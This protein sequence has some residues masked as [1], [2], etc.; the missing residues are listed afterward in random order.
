[1]LFW[2]ASA[3]TVFQTADNRLIFQLSIA[4]TIS[5]SSL[6]LKMLSLICVQ[7]Y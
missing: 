3:I 4:L 2:M 7:K 5:F 1:M 6:M